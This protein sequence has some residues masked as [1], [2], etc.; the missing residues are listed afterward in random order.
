MTSLTD[1]SENKETAVIPEF[2]LINDQE[3]KV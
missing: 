2:K 1:V 3:F